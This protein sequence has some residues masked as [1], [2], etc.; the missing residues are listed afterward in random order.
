MTHKIIAYLLL[1][2]GLTILFFGLISMYKVFVD[3]RPVINIVQMQELSFKTQNG[4]VQLQMAGLNGL[5]NISLFS[6]F[7]VFLVS[8]GAKTANIGINLLK[9]ERI[10][11]TLLTL[12]RTDVNDRE[13]ELTKL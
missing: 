13:S 5:I 4:P 7:M 9:T 10:C 6:L 1:L 11:E 8:L 12:R 3:H 2:A